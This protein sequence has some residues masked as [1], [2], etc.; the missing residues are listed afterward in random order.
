MLIPISTAPRASAN[1]RAPALFIE[2]EVYNGNRAQNHPRSQRRYTGSRPCVADT[3]AFQQSRRARK[4]V[5]M[6]FA[7]MKRIIREPR[8]RK[9]IP[10]AEAAPQ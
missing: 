3:E 2:A 6:Q 9:I 4:K 5:E 1:D 10:I 8:D 7:H